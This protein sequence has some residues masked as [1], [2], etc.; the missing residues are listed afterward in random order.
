MAESF[1]HK[2]LADKRKEIQAYIGSLERDLEKARRDLSAIVVTE[3]VFQAKGPNVTADM[4]L[5]FLFPRHELPRLAR[6]AMEANPDGITAPQIASHVIAVKG[7]AVN[8]RHLK[9]SIGYKVVQIMRR[10]ERERKAVRE[11]KVGTAIIYGLAAAPTR[12]R[13]PALDASPYISPSLGLGDLP[14]HDT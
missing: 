9:R 1:I 10:W 3:H 7:P 6:A 12:P 8:D 4:E 14:A 5:S 11:K 13:A 2:N